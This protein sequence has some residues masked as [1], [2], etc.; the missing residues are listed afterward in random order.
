MT[1]KKLKEYLSKP[2]IL[3]K[4]DEGETLFLYLVVFDHTISGV[5]VRK[6]EGVQ[7]P[8]Y[9]VSKSLVQAKTHYSMIEKLVSALITSVRK[10]RPYFQCH[11]N[12]I[13]NFGK[14]TE[15][16]FPMSSD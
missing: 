1:F 7:K 14:E 16:I 5:L 6:D 9:Y 13:N 10:L 15:T 4:L 12:S 3:S 2:L 11:L 8:I